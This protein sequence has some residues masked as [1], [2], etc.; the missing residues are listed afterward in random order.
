MEIHPDDEILK[1]ICSG[2]KRAE[3]KFTTDRFETLFKEVV[4]NSSKTGGGHKKQIMVNNMAKM[5]LNTSSPARNVSI[6]K[7]VEK[8]LDI[9]DE[10]HQKLGDLKTASKDIS[11][12][13]VKIESEKENLIP[14]LN[15]LSDG[16]KLK[17]ILN[18]TLVTSSLEILKFNRG[19]YIPS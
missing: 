2:R 11:P 17:G 3:K 5:Q 13:I 19:D 16:D 12:L 14:A 18:Q 4:K 15:F 9:L 10:Y 7:H 8:L 1:S 6:V